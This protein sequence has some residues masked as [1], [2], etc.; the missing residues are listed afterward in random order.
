M[1]KIFLIFSSA[2]LMSVMSS[3]P[4][5]AIQQDV[6]AKKADNNMVYVGPD[7]VIESNF[8]KAGNMVEVAG[9]V[10]GDLFVAGNMINV[11]GKIE[12]D[13]F[14]VGSMI[15]INDQVE[16]NVRVLG[17]NVEIAGKI[18]RNVSA[19]GGNVVIN[20]GTHIGWGAQLAGGNVEIRGR[21]NRSAE[22]MAGNLIIA[23][24]VVGDV[25]A[26]IGDKNQNNGKLAVYPGAMVGGNL[27][28]TAKDKAAIE[29]GAKINGQVIHNLPDYQAAKIKA[30]A[31]GAMGLSW[32]LAKL[33]HL[34]GLIVIGF[35]LV[36]M[37]PKVAEKMNDLMV[38]K[39]WPNLGW[40]LIW[41]LLTPIVCLILMLTLIGL[42]LALLTMAIYLISLCIV[43][44][45]AGLALG[46]YI[47]E[48]FG[49][50]K[51]NMMWSMV[52][53][54][55]VLM[56]LKSI[57]FVGWIIGLIFTWWGI[58]AM[59]AFKKEEAKKWR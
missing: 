53:G 44:V 12:G 17:S 22:V 59:I 21:M 56:V 13:I 39:F 34:F 58:G 10:N 8:Y 26:P 2:L 50:K 20:P 55:F 38:K 18:A 35:L 6:S 43:K 31:L 33:V 42:P 9:T 54:V 32:M 49:K 52:L 24:E 15:K 7:E 5:L 19:I 28:Y 37:V 45:Y 3:S 25:K 16:G 40:G 36:G 47:I 48:A 27:K 46:K 51:P 41:F 29:Q 14:A 4:V 1:K 30:G 23:G 11:T 57:P